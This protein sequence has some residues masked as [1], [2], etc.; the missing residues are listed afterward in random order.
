MALEGAPGD[1]VERDEVAGVEQLGCREHLER[2][3]G[4]VEG[5]I[6]GRSERVARGAQTA[7]GGFALAVGSQSE[8]DG[9]EDEQRHDGHQ[10]QRD[11]VRS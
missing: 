4:V 6:D 1:A 10:H 9:R 3:D 7:L 8:H 2:T 11:Q 5:V